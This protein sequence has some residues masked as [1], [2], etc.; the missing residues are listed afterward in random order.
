[1]ISKL[2]IMTILGQNAINKYCKQHI[3][4]SIENRQSLFVTNKAQL[5]A[6]VLDRYKPQINTDTMLDPQNNNKTLLID[7]ILIKNNMKKIYED[8]ATN[9]PSH[10]LEDFQ[11]WQREY[12]PKP[13]ITPGIYEPI[14]RPFTVNEVLQIITH[15][16]NNKSPG[17]S[18]IPYELWKHLN[19]NHLQ[20]LVSLFNNILETNVIPEDWKHSIIFPITKPKP[21]EKDLRMTRPIALLETARKIFTKGIYNRIAPILTKH[22]I[23]SESNWAG[24]PGGSTAGPIHIIN[25]CIEDAREKQKP[26]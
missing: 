13:K 10:N 17:S 9:T 12:T 25:N 8:W 4:A 20:E 21:W 1:V 7:P 26:L 24:L 18:K 23:L 16:S 19:K 2:K 5:L 6:K 14:L 15:M 22:K 11:E 3:T